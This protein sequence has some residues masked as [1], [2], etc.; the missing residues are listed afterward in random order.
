MELRKATSAGSA[1]I[2]SAVAAA[3]L[4]LGYTV[5]T[6]SVGGPIVANN[7]QASDL[8]ADILPP[9]VYILES[10]LEARLAVAEPSRLDEHA[11]KL[12]KLQADYEARQQHWRGSTLPD[13]LKSRLKKVD[14][15]AER[16]FSEVKN[17]FLPALKNGD[18]AGISASVDRLARTYADHR[19]QI[20]VLVSETTSYQ[21]ATSASGE[22]HRT[23]ALWTMALAGLALALVLVAANVL[24]TRFAITPLKAVADTMRRMATGELDARVDV[25][26][27][28][29]EIA[30]MTSAIEVFRESSKARLEAEQTQAFVVKEL[31]D[32]LDALAGKNLAYRIETA[33]P[34]AYEALRESFNS[35][36]SELCAVLAHTAASAG[37]VLNGAAEIRTASNDLALRT[38]Q[39]AASLE[40]S[41][42]AM[43]EVTTMVQ[44]TALNAAAVGQEMS[45]AHIS[46]LD[47]GKVVARAV[48][49]MG[50]IQKSAGEITS[51]I[52]V[53]DGIAFQTNLLAL[54]AGVEAARAGEA[55]KGFA[56]VATEV[57]ALAQRSAD[58]ARDIKQLISASNSSVSEGVN[59]VGETGSV[60]SQIGERVA[61][62]NARILEMAGSA[63]LQS[64]RLQQVNQSVS[65]MDKMTQQNAA[66][67]EESNA[68]ARSLAEEATDLSNLVM[69]FRTG[70]ARADVPVAWSTTRAQRPMGSIPP[71]HGN[72]AVK[73]EASDEDWAE[74]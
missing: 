69:T 47:G 14:A 53:I 50:A 70:A 30:S 21:A 57:R 4:Y 17:V 72:L 29:E 24:L 60:L 45:E 67:V 8:V 19:R 2:F 44:Q 52:D 40:E 6:I 22:S 13:S 32:G 16:F 36:T 27:P 28:V 73:L 3:A 42:A 34:D 38:E 25:H 62:I 10:Y 5:N 68:A 33:F 43:R 37:N 7:Q 31:T 9:P 11:E 65:D 18:Q 51:I 39:Q 46:T 74:F 71:R 54:N 23:F 35:T 58:A 59:L 15:P 48:D 56:V 61:S 49:A 26:D 12:Q 55:G 64:S 66:M 1:V 41:A 20:D 63:Q